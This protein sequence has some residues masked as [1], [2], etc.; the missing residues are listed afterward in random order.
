MPEITIT[1]PHGRLPAYLAT[2][3]GTG[4]W[5][6]V[7]VVHDAFG[8]TNDL[9]R[10]CDWLAASGYL[11]VGP[12]LYSWG[13]KLA[14]VR[15][16]MRDLKNRRGRA[17]DELEAARQWLEAE[18]RGTGR[19][20][21]IGYC[22]GGGFALLLA[23]GRGYAA[24]SVNYGQVPDD[25]GSLLAGACPVVGS[26]GARDRALKG[27]AAK[28]EEAL[29]QQ[30]VPHDVVEYPDA[31]HGFLNDHDGMVGAFV[32]VA[33]PLAGLGYHEPSADDARRRIVAFFDRYLR[34]GGE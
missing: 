23:P 27:A 34:P 15:A 21:V 30:A 10:Q 12:D 28:L 24:S 9:R 29:E 31:G 14:C 16:V 3:P 20:G 7:V 6:G 1:S 32:R 13:R 4:A 8:I 5:P 26:Y 2:P 19:V 17:F 18:P 22:M 25:A 11:A 33:G